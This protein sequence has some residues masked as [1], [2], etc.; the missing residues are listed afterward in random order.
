MI[1]LS[2]RRDVPEFMDDP[3]LPP[4]TYRRC[5]TDL[6]SVNRWTLTHRP[7]LAWLS[8]ATRT[9]APGAELR[10]LDVACG[11]GDLLR[12][13]HRRAS[14]AGLVPLLAGIDLNPRSAVTAAAAT[15]TG[16][17]IE[18]RTGDVFDHQPIPP[19]DF[20]VSSQFAH[21][22][23]D[24][25]VVA[26]LQWLDRHARRGWLVADLHRSLLPYYGFPLLAW[27]MRWHRIVRTDGTASI[28]RSF[29]RADWLA[30]LR[31]AGIE[32]ATVRWGVPF[33]YT[34]GRPR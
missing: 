1:D 13:I 20:I 18:W 25:R 19:P 32:G 17:V 23:T 6:A 16:M 29:R 12:A 14:R 15:P 21:H 4:D 27:A 8:R 34:V 31:Q 10:V 28:A 30:L 33:R 7:T 3:D 5:L 2:R 22:L 24:E 11:D 9:F 26:F